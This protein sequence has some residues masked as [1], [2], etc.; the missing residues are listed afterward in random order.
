MRISY[1]YL[2]VGSFP[3]TKGVFYLHGERVYYRWG[4]LSDTEISVQ[5][6]SYSSEI[7]T[8]IRAVLGRIKASLHVEQTPQFLIAYVSRGMY[9]V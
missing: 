3:V 1:D 5:I 8:I 4:W 2:A 6:R 9:A 7:D